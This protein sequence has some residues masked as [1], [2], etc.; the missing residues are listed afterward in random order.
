LL[1]R[2]AEFWLP[3]EAGRSRVDVE[4]GISNSYLYSHLSL[5]SIL[6]FG[7]RCIPCGNLQIVHT[8]VEAIFGGR[9]STINPL[10]EF[11]FD[12]LENGIFVDRAENLAHDTFGTVFAP[13]GSIE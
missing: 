1:A 3:L 9:G 7:E 6:L 5:Y 12:S 13:V 8:L 10:L 4:L 11:P 2:G